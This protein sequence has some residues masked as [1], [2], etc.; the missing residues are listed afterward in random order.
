MA[1]ACAASSNCAAEGACGSGTQMARGAGPLGGVPS[2]SEAAAAAAAD[3]A[4][5]EYGTAGRNKKR[6]EVASD[7]SAATATTGAGTDLPQQLTGRAAA[8]TQYRM[9]LMRV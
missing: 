7:S 4:R 9:L 2:G 1:T 5:R 3:M 6:A 8:V